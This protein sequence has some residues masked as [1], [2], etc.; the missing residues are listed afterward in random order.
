MCTLE[1]TDILV[2]FSGGKD[3]SLILDLSKRGVRV[4]TKPAG[5]AA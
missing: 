1:G 2:S 5:F 4:V 3:S